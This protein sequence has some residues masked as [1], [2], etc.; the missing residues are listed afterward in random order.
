MEN[1]NSKLITVSFAAGGV[2]LGVTLALLMGALAG[3]FGWVA[4]AYDLNWVRHGVPVVVGLGL[5][6]AL[7][8][9]PKAVQWAEEVIVEIKK[10]VWP[11]RKD[12]T[13]MT[14]VTLVMVLI[15]S[16]IVTSFDFVSSKLVSW[17]VQ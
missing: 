13:A 8:F 2:I 10:V 1:S 11:S 15:S 3:A 12:T 7:Q 5:F 14:I 4:R 9:N 6:V 16:L 17:I